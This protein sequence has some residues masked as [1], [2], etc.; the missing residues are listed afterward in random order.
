[1]Y[2]NMYGCKGFD[3]DVYLNTDDTDDNE[4]DVLPSFYRCEH[5]NH[6]SGLVYFSSCPSS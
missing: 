4:W 3:G 2:I 6:S 5:P 1:M